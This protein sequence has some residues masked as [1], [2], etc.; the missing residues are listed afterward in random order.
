MRLANE[1]YKALNN[2]QFTLSDMINLEKAFDLV[3]HKGL[4]YRMEPLDQ[5]GNVLQFVED[6]LKDPTQSKF[7]SDQPCG[8]SPYFLKNGTPQDSVPSPLLF[9]VIINDLPESSNDVKLS[10][11][12]DDSS[13]WKS[14]P[15]LLALSRDVQRY[16]TE[17]AKYFEEWGF[18]ISI[19]KTVAILF[20]RSIHIPTDEVILKV[21][22]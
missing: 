9:I 18:K 7:A 15:N 12:A 21:D 6:F 19:N 11:F 4:L 16:L 8:S 5:H 13:L 20:S 10:L 1:D 2:N 14:G 17:T 3:W 22:Q